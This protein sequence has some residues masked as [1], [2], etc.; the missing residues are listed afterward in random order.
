MPL[1]PTLFVPMRNLGALAL[2]GLV[3]TTLASAQTCNLGQPLT[4][5]NQGNVG[6][7]VYFNLT[8]TNTVTFSSLTYVASDTSLAG[9]SSF[10]MFVG[11]STWVG[12]VGANPGPWTLVAASTPVAIPG[13]V[14]TTVVGV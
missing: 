6:G 3:L 9:N 8:V 13:A 10:N 1:V 14:D 11:P 5:A 2:A 12:N 4:S 7:G